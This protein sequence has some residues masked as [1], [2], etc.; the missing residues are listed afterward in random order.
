VDDV[1]NEVK[2]ERMNRLIALYRSIVQKV[3]EALIGTEQVVL[4]EGVSV[5]PYASRIGTFL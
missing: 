3:N 5:L 2:A 4:I 1:P